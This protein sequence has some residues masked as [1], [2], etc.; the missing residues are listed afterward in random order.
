MKSW[1]HLLTLSKASSLSQ[2]TIIWK[3][4]LS[5]VDW[6]PTDVSVQLEEK[7]KNNYNPPNYQQIILTKI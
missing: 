6:R 1:G 2:E 3:K 5:V 4:E 7:Q